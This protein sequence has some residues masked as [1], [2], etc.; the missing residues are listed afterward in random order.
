LASTLAKAS[1]AGWV[2][3]PS[4]EG[5]RLAQRR[6]ASGS[7]GAVAR[8]ARSEARRW[9]ISAACVGGSAERAANGAEGMPGWPMAR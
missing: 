1:A 9:A 4:A 5:E 3:V 6:E 7:S 8:R 2:T